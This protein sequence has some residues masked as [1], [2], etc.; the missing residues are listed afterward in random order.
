MCAIFGIVGEYNR[1][2]IKKMSAIQKY[3]GPDKTKFFFDKKNNFSIGMNRLSVI[4]KKNGIQPMFSWDKKIIC[5]FNGTIYNFNEIKNFLIKKNVSFRTN[6]D[7]EVLVNSFSY[8]GKKC[9]N[10]F[11]GMWAAGFFDFK[12]KIFTL[13]RDYVGQKP[14]FYS[15]INKKKLIFSSQLNGI[16][17]YKKKFFVNR[18]NLKLYH[19]FGYTPA[20]YTIYDEIFQVSPGEIITFKKDLKKSIFWD[21]KNGPNYNFFF[22]RKSKETF[23]ENIPSIVKNYL[24]ADKLPALSLSSGLDSNILRFNLQKLKINPNMFTIGFLS[25][26]YDEIKDVFN[27]KKIMHFKKKMN[28]KDIINSFSAIK[29]K[30]SFAN[31][32]GSII[33]T[34]FLFKQIKKSNNVCIGG[35]GGD[36]VF[37]GY[38]TFKAF[39]LVKKLKQFIPLKLL[40]FVKKNFFNAALSNDY[41]DLNKKLNLFFKYI[42]SELSLINTRWLN[43]IDNDQLIELS[44]IKKK[45]NEIKKIEKLF[46]Y[47]KNNMRFCQL[48]YFKYYLPTVLDKVDN[49]SMYNS[50]ESRSPFLN[51]ELINLS[52]D[53]PVNK[54]FSLFKNKKLLIELYGNNIPKKIKKIK[55]HGFSFPK[56][57]ILKNK[58]LVMNNI[59]E[60]LLTNKIFFKQKY[61]E[62]LRNNNNENYIWNELILNITRQNLEKSN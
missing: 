49:A 46:K 45:H 39:W 51:K 60:S 35:D 61:N 38:V 20:P 19:Q 44:G 40:T 25:K 10:Y 16:F 12:K 33:P 13:S 57:I 5:I 62:Y 28:S 27:K 37:F 3:R 21:L 2:I 17:E 42:D 23:K 29:K 47:S 18:E 1:Q 14:L 9:F 15:L 54:N 34:H 58:D 48:Y 11:D 22:K 32:D 53:T 24:I 36:E 30:I 56:N 59:N 4:D 43:N 41:L 6:S 8:W 52:L 7:T 50:V 55:K 26:S 31:G